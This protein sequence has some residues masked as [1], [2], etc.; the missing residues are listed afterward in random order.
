MYTILLFGAMA[1]GGGAGD[2]GHIE[3]EEEHEAK[4]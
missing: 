3:T 2:D 4:L 1:I